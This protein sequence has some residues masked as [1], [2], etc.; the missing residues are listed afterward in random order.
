MLIVE[1][2]ILLD[3]NQDSRLWHRTEKGTGNIKRGCKTKQMNKYSVPLF[4]LK[5]N[6]APVVTAGGKAHDLEWHK[7]AMETALGGDN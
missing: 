5:E 7:A 1:I 6:E 4:L 2:T 3:Q